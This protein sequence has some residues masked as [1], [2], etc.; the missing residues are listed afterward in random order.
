MLVA[1]YHPFDLEHTRDMLDENIAMV[2]LEY[3]GL[4]AR[5]A[6]YSPRRLLTTPPEGLRE[7]GAHPV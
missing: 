6:E 2:V 7:A 3:F 4:M 5:C 1:G